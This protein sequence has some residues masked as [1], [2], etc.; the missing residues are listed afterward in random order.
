MEITYDT[1]MAKLSK[2]LT[3]DPTTVPTPVANAETIKAPSYFKHEWMKFPP[4]DGNI[5]KYA[6]WEEDFET[7]IKPSCSESQVA[8]DLN[9]HL[10]DELREEMDALGGTETETWE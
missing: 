7:H 3:P 5:R 10:C 1:I 4:F 2:D 6:K 8:F 9:S